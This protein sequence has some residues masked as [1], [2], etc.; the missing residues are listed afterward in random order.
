MAGSG[1]ILPLRRYCDSLVFLPLGT[2]SKVFDTQSINKLL[3]LL[4]IFN[5][6]GRPDEHK[7]K[8]YLESKDLMINKVTMM[9]QPDAYKRS[10]RVSV[11]TCSDYDKLLSGE[12]LPPFVGVKKFIFGRNKANRSNSGQWSP[13]KKDSDVINDFINQSNTERSLLSNLSAAQGGLESDGANNHTISKIIGSQEVNST[14]G[15]NLIP[16]SLSVGGD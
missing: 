7:V 16:D 9:S 1:A 13:G 2:S 5:C 10:F 11:A 14:A 3:L 15:A 8:K 12:P 4:F 6:A